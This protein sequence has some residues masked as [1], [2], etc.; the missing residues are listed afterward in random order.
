MLKDLSDDVG[1]A[2]L[3][4]EGRDYHQQALL[5]RL[6]VGHDSDSTYESVGPWITVG[7]FTSRFSSPSRAVHRH[8]QR[9]VPVMAT[10]SRARVWLFAFPVFVA[11]VF[12]VLVALDLNGSSI[13]NF[14]INPE[15]DPSLVAGQPRMIRTDEWAIGTP[16]A[17]GVARQGFPT[18]PWIGLTPTK[19]DV[20]AYRG[21][22]GG[23]TEAFH[24]YNWG[25]YAFGASRGMAF[26]WWFGMLASLVGIF[27]LVRLIIGSNWIAGALAAVATFCPYVAWWSCSP[28][29]FAGLAAGAGACAIAAGRATTKW[30]IF[31]FSLLAGYLLVALVLTLYPPW[32]V[33][34]VWVVIAMVV[35]QYIDWRLPWRRLLGIA[36]TAGGL[37]VAAL[38]PWYLQNRDA[39]ALIAGTY[40][41]GQRVSTPG[42]ATWQFLMDAPVNFW[43]TAENVSLRKSTNLSEIASAWLPLPILAVAAVAAIVLSWQRRSR[44][45]DAQ[46]LAQADT[47]PELAPRAVSSTVA[48]PLFGRATVLLTA[49]VTLFLVLW[50][51]VP[52]PAIIGKLT[53][54][55]SVEGGRMPLAL[56]LGAVL[57]TAMAAAATATRGRRLPI[58]LIVTWGVAGIATIGLT[59]WAAKLIPW[60][61][62][63][64]SLLLIA[65]S[66]AAVAVGFI[67]IATGWFGRTA[68]V[69]L[70]L[71]CFVSW[72]LVNPLYQGL[73]PLTSD[74]LVVAT[75]E[76]LRAEPNAVFANFGYSLTGGLLQASGAQPRSV[77]TFY[78]DPTV[79]NV[80][81]PGDEKLWNNYVNYVWI[82][83]PYVD[84]AYLTQTKSSPTVKEL[85]INPCGSQLR[86]LGITWIYSDWRM[87]EPCLEPVDIIRRAEHQR[88]YRY[89]L[90]DPADV[91]RPS[92]TPVR[93]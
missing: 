7:W 67:L 39:L 73:G 68:A 91:V 29:L 49:A 89:R 28:A 23:W 78:P 34:L 84:Q 13:G 75:R 47:V 15:Q 30:R 2:V 93:S 14:S 65:A 44:H 31:G 74:P 87:R 60:R 32:I 83:D 25:Y 24:P 36:A 4:I 38:V 70:V 64:A 22:T 57:L 58:W 71:Y 86:Y 55:S 51:V 45:S 10:G 62:G 20:T 63:S 41:P 42:G 35:G 48:Q 66:A 85:H 82:S 6:V 54:L 69:G 72:A 11:L 1:D 26:N 56:G 88:V 12:T 76:T 16:M 79:M 5:A 19:L 3:L 52:L 9:I 81:A 53:L 46:V 80:V 59:L 77:T 40:Y 17:I 8:S 37:T 61:S 27:A 21:P 18:Q 92:R 50:A 90:K 43:M 33:S